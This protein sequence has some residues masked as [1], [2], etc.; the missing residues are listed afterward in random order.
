MGPFRHPDRAVGVALAIVAQTSEFRL[1]ERLW[2]D[3]L[4]SLLHQRFD[5]GPLFTARASAEYHARIP[6]WAW[7]QKHHAADLDELPMSDRARVEVFLSPR[8]RKTIWFRHRQIRVEHCDTPLGEVVGVAYGLPGVPLTRS[9]LLCSGML[10]P[11]GPSVRLFGRVLSQQMT[12]NCVFCP[13]VEKLSGRQ[14]ET[15]EHL[16][17]GATETAIAKAMVRSPHTVHSYVKGLYRRFGVNG[18]PELMS[19][20]N[21]KVTLARPWCEV[22]GQSQPDGLPI[23]SA[24]PVHRVDRTRAAAKPGVDAKRSRNE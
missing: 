4:T 17:N 12:R 13:T 18:K 15:L 20:F 24:R 3:A 1:D 11:F 7:L 16:L 10:Q 23:P 8:I 6:V 5:I 19:L 14:A 22:S 2:H 21:Q 9:T